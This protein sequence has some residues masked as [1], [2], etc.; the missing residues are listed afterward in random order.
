MLGIAVPFH[1]TTL[2]VVLLLL[3][4]LV[5]NE[6]PC[7]KNKNPKKSLKKPTTLLAAFYT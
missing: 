2:L 3:L 1:V 4:L 6:A 5:R 7:E